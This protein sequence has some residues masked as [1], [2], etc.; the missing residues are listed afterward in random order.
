MDSLLP[1]HLLLGLFAWESASF[2]RDF[3]AKALVVCCVLMASAAALTLVLFPIRHINGHPFFDITR[4]PFFLVFLVAIIFAWNLAVISRP[5]IEKLFW[6]NAVAAF[7]IFFM[8]LLLW[9][10]LPYALFR[11]TFD[12]YGQMV[13]FFILVIPTVLVWEGLIESDPSRRSGSA[14]STAIMITALSAF[15]A[16]AMGSE[17]WVT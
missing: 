7:L 13:S 8:I 16:V 11:I 9:Y 10:S 6:L 4:I 3:S 15:F 1:R 17:S 12:S 5:S 2:I 14:V